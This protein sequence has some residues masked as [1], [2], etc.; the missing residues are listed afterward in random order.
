[1]VSQN[2]W[3]TNH[4]SIYQWKYLLTSNHIAN[5]VIVC[6]KNTHTHTKKQQKKK[7]KKKKKNKQTKKKNSFLYKINEL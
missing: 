4:K 2:I 5:T 1:M 6:K 7:T 3:V